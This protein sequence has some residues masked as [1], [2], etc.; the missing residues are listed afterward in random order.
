MIEC[1]SIDLVPVLGHLFGSFCLGYFGLT[2]LSNE[3]RVASN[4]SILPS[5]NSS[6][7][8]TQGSYL[9]VS[10]VWVVILQLLSA[11]CY[12]QLCYYYLCENASGSQF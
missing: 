12:S 4:R 8:P 10:L 9:V 7:V 3:V 11:P 6:V 2:T 5:G 1:S